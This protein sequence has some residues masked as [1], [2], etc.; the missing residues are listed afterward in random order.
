M[1]LHVE[2]QL[3]LTSFNMAN[4]SVLIITF[5]LQSRRLVQLVQCCLYIFLKHCGKSGTTL[6]FINVE[7]AIFPALKTFA[8][9][10]R[11]DRLFCCTRPYNKDLAHGIFI[12]ASS[13]IYL[14]SF[15]IIL[16][17]RGS[18]GVTEWKDLLTTNGKLRSKWVFE[19]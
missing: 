3:N 11:V 15:I 1:R 4:D 10:K 18:A 13:A 17:V 7:F 12:F 9:K 8:R 6:Q 14:I 19:D 16:R 2:S 5:L